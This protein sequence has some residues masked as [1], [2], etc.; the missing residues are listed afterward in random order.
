[1]KDYI[2]FFASKKIG[3]EILALSK[4]RRH[5]LFIDGLRDSDLVINL[6]SMS[7]K[8]NRL[9]VVCSNEQKALKL[10]QE[11]D[12][13][14]SNTDVVRLFF[15][16]SDS[17]PL[18]K[19]TSS[20]NLISWQISSLYRL[21]ESE[22]PVVMTTSLPA[23]YD[24]LI[25]VKT[26]KESSIL[27]SKNDIISLEN[28][29]TKLLEF[30]YK[31]QH[32]V[33]SVGD[34]AVRGGIIDV[35]SPYQDNPSRIEFDIDVIETIR[36]VNIA[37][38]LSSKHVDSVVIL[39]PSHIILDKTRI[40]SAISRINMFLLTVRSVDSELQAKVNTD[41]EH[42]KNGVRFSGIEHYIPFFNV[43]TTRLLDYI[44][45]SP[46]AWID[47][48]ELSEK[49]R[50]FRRDAEDVYITGL[51]RGELLPQRELDDI[52]RLE[53]PH[54]TRQNPS[55]SIYSTRTPAP[56]EVKRLGIQHPQPDPLIG[57]LQDVSDYITSKLKSGYRIV[58]GT[59][60]PT[61]IAELLLN[62]EFKKPDNLPE[63][64]ED[65]EEI[66]P[67]IDLVNISLEKG[68]EDRRKKILLL[69]DNELFGWRRKI[70]ATRRYKGGKPITSIDEINPGDLLVH[71]TFGIG[72]Y[73]GLKTV[74]AGG[75][76]K[77]Y[78][79]VEYSKGDKL[80]IP[81]ERLTLVHKYLGNP[82]TVSINRLGGKEWPETLAKVARGTKDIAAKLLKIYAKR[83]L[84]QGIQY[85]GNSIWQQEMESAFPYE[86]TEDQLSAIRDVKKDLESKQ[87][88]D[89][90]VCGDVGYGKTEI[91]IR[92]AFKVIV[93]GKQ[94][95][96]L[97]PTTILAMQ[98]FNTFKERFAPFPITVDHLSR[99]KSKKSQ[100]KT[101]A[102]LADGSI[103]MVI[104]T[105]RLLSN[106]VELKIIG[107]LI[108]DEEQRFGVEAKEKIKSLKESIDVLT[109]TATPIPRTLE[110]TLHGVREVSQINSSPEGRKPVKTYVLPY[111]DKTVKEAIETEI[112][113]GG[114][115]YY[116]NN[117]I[118]GLASIE[119][120]L[121][122][123]VPKARIM[124]AH[125]R[126]SELDLEDAMLAFY[127]G[128]VDI[129]L[130]TTIIESGLDIPSAST[131]IVENAQNLGLAQMYQ[132]RGRVGRSERRAYA[133]FLY[134]NEK[135]LTGV[136]KERLNAI[137]DFVELG[138]GLK[139]AMRDLEIRGAGNILGS[140][141][142]GHISAI[143]YDLYLRMLDDAKKRLEDE[144]K[145]VVQKPSRKSD[146][147]CNVD[148]RISGYIPERYIPDEALRIDCYQRMI[149]SKNLDEVYKIELEL[150]D[151]FGHPPP[152]IESLF[153]LV[154][155]RVMGARMGITQ[156]VEDN[157]TI[158]FHF[159]PVTRLREDFL[160]RLISR[161]G[162]RT[163]IR[164]NMIRIR[165][166]NEN[167]VQISSEFIELA[168]EED[169]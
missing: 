102:G 16:H 129:L 1:M 125:G 38:Q 166:Q 138:A 11:M 52:E 160:D 99:I 15:P 80:Y 136:A 112:A 134:P 20:I 121:K 131:L 60:Q 57:R 168:C 155:L 89:R 111:S 31:Q 159:G 67:F 153:E 132:L 78:L 130:C 106:D 164:P 107:L 77:E 141:Q 114:Q 68:F 76:T 51:K 49:Y 65:K 98:H 126:M 150:E 3:N 24:C 83:E 61:R 124:I 26:L 145:G 32:Q 97:V 2:P 93:S 103:E 19:T 56:A 158:N 28:L 143:G 53:F 44:D 14:L 105:H 84:S 21:L 109:L 12:G 75:V 146:S 120:K 108:I 100:N 147:D 169:V 165:K 35:F 140:E 117:R 34:M 64:P 70:K 69:T 48:N 36:E 154:K 133:Y 55:I 47:P 13:I 118:R 62:H 110:M 122:K 42:I 167:P 135:A 4:G 142:S 88:M 73:Q 137:K 63:N 162:N 149:Q 27:L 74:K 54:I 45:S 41:I 39:P 151:R 81:P 113:R 71:L 161:F 92:A 30:G 119:W 10:H 90:L 43:K 91:A 148:L 29:K 82:E 116:V 86:E 96:M 9:L 33:E 72:I 22:K 85:K 157:L 152:E 66:E 95:V 6:A 37:T 101:V 128:E 94:V 40:E 18:D 8:I 127:R 17:I 59:K 79:Q 123:L 156:I 50:S 104:G 87:P 144:R 163:T 115:I 7:S 139:L 58:I 5:R 25:D 46:V 23:L